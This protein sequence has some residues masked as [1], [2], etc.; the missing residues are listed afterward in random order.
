[1]I[2]DQ[3]VVGQLYQIHDDVQGTYVGYSSER[4]SIYF[5]PQGNSDMFFSSS[6]ERLEGCIGFIASCH[7]I[8]QFQIVEQQSK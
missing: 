2:Q 3:L 7:T 1:M 6:F 5:K 8:D 4:K